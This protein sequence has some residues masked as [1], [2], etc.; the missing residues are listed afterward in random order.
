MQST[1]LFLTRDVK[2]NSRFSGLTN[3]DCSV[4]EEKCAQEVKCDA[5]HKICATN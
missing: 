2:M 5:R 3:L 4:G 1:V